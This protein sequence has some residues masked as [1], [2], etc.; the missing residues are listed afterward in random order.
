MVL[1]YHG[2]LL[3]TGRRIAIALARWNNFVGEHLLQ[4]AL[5]ALQRHGVDGEDIVVVR[6]P[7]SFEL[8]FIVQR[9]ARREPRFD[10]IV[11]LGAL[12][13]GGTPHF[14]YLAAEATKGIAQV[15]LETDLPVAYGVLTCDT[16]EQAIERAGS[17]AGNKGAEAALAALEMADLTARLA[18]D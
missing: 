13:R 15:S 8:P 18:G 3:G 17:K 16:L 5:D 2:K 9:L 12:I 4:C 14:D 7:G 6:V 10:A 1:E 11:A